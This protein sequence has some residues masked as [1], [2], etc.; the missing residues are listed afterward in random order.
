MTRA[1]I[2]VGSNVGDRMETIAGAV[3]AL[4][5]LDETRV[6]AVSHVYESEP[7]GLEDQPA[8]A[9]AVVAIDTDLRAD[10]LLE[11]LRNIEDRFGRVRDV[12][13]GPRTIDLDILLFGDEEWTLP[14]LTIPHPRM[15]KRDFVITP[16]LEIAPD[17]TW[18]DGSYVTRE[19]V[20]VGAVTSVLGAMPDEEAEQ[21]LPPLAEEDWV[22]VAEG[23]TTPV[24]MGLTFKQ[25][26]LEQAEIPFSW[27][28]FPPGD[29]TQPWGMPTPVKLVGPADRAEE[30]RRLLAEAD[31][32][33]LA[34]GD[35]ED[36]EPTDEPGF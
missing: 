25:L 29:E 36:E 27:D 1:Y 11:D 10:Q 24:D 20:S 18:P 19:S 34:S 28:P 30:A 5:E 33:P 26:V 14:E 8:F 32:A 35:F 6:D 12:P 3:A 31:S 21:G 13:N 15:A 7:A 16:L 22:A 2:G 9:N 4:E 17:V 23:V